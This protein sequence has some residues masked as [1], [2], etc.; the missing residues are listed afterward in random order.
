NL[1]DLLMAQSSQSVEPPRKPGRFSTP[2]SVRPDWCLGNV[3][4]VE[5]KN[6]NIDK[7]QQGLIDNVSK[8]AVQRAENLPQGMAQ[9][10]VI[11]VRGQ[12]VTPLQRVQIIRGIVDKS[13]GRISPSSI[14]FKTE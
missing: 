4:S 14:R 5:V 7:N 10:V 6:Y 1:F 2:G 11:D 3:C 8:Q 13:G 9:Q 12:T